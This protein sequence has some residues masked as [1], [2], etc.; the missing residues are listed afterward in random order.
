M[1]PLYVLVCMAADLDSECILYNFEN[2]G[3]GI[4]D[5]AGIGLCMS[6]VCLF[7]QINDVRITLNGN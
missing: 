4:I 2:L 7:S 6:M 3:L 1:V 5:I